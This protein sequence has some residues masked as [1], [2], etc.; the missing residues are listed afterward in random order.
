MLL[1]HTDL[2]NNL[3]TLS[4]FFHP[5]QIPKNITGNLIKQI[6][7]VKSAQMPTNNPYFAII[8]FKMK[9]HSFSIVSNKQ[10]WLRFLAEERGR[11]GVPSFSTPSPPLAVFLANIH[12]FAPSHNL[13]RWNRRMNAEDINKLEVDFDEK[14]QYFSHIIPSILTCRNSRH[15][16]QWECQNALYHT[17]RTAVIYANPTWYQ[18]HAASL[19]WNEKR[20]MIRQSQ[21]YFSGHVANS[22]GKQLVFVSVGAS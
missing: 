9:G 18:S 1:L 7:T 14:G 19:H 6:K 21:S 8:I 12:L 11:E 3:E 15:S 10:T 5:D 22:S 16:C 4:H 2:L 20:Q 17:H 13:N